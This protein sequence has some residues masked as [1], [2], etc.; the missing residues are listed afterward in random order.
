MLDPKI[1]RN[2]A[3][4]L[5]ENIKS[6]S[7][8]QRV[9]DQISLFNKVLLESE[10]LRAVLY[11]PVVSKSTKLNLM[12]NFAK[13]FKFER[14][15]KQFFKIIV[16]NSRF[17]I[18]PFVIKEYIYLFNESRG[19]KSVTLEFANKPD[20]KLINFIKSYLEGQLKRT[21]E[22]HQVQN[23]SL[24]GGVVIKYDSLL[25]DFSIAGA[26]DRIA[27]IAKSVKVTN[28]S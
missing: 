14:L 25:Y 27:K 22:F 26:V 5:F 6:E 17:E 8:R 15:V 4:C 10:Q 9:L 7:E 13:K 24:I 12:A 18:L 23:D 19:I 11:S 2:Y 20:Q 21:I 3:L 16:K 1:V 28:V